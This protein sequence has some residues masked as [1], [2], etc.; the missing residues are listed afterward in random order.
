[1]EPLFRICGLS[2]VYLGAVDELLSKFLPAGRVV[3]VADREVIRLHPHLLGRMERIEIAAGEGSKTLQTIE[4][5]CREFVRLGVDRSTFILGVGG[6]VATDM[7]GFAASVFMRGVRFGFVS[8]TLLGQVDASVGGKNGVNLDGYKN[9]IGVF[10]QPEFVVCDPALLA[11]LSL[12]EF[13]AGLAE[14]V[15]SAIIADPDLFDLLEDCSFEGVRN[16]R[17][18]LSRIIAASIRVKADIVSRDER[19]GGER[20]KL[21]LGH[22]FAHAIEKCS[23]EMN[24]GEAVAVGLRLVTD[25]AVKTHKL[26]FEDHARILSLLSKYGFVLTPPAPLAD[27]KAAAA[28]DKKQSGGVLNLV[29]PYGVGHCEVVPVTHEQFDRLF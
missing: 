29:L 2:E 23:S 1:M 15:K 21:N 14:V 19:E 20:R 28:K 6:G 22:T 12:R 26:S 9:M 10:N 8:T 11:S 5:I 17:A 13:R 27:L 7:V 24:H 16:D 25:A 4:F 18:I 3:A